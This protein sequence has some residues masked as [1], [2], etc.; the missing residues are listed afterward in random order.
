MKTNDDKEGTEKKNNI[1]LVFSMMKWIF[2]ESMNRRWSQLIDAGY[3]T[4]E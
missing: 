3:L 4:D 2:L 1:F